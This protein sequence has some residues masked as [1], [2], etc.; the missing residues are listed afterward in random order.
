MQHD[1]GVVRE[2]I[3]KEDESSAR[4]AFGCS[5]DGESAYERS[6]IAQ[7]LSK[8]PAFARIKLWLIRLF[9]HLAHF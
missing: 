9:R 4:I 3:R 6:Q 8:Q 2:P 7:W 1:G 5:F